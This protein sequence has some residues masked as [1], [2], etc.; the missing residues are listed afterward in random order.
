M[1]LASQ[2]TKKKITLGKIERVIERRS[3]ADDT[4]KTKVISIKFGRNSMR[5]FISGFIGDAFSLVKDFGC[6]Q[7][8]NAKEEMMMMMHRDFESTEKKNDDKVETMS[9]LTKRARASEYIYT[10]V[11]KEHRL[12]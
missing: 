5:D 11:R 6:A 1:S 9:F 2:T 3:D 7:L 10:Y 12:A 8:R 4:L